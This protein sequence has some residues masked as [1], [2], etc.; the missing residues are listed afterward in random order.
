MRLTNFAKNIPNFI[1]VKM[2]VAVK[3]W[4][5]LGVFLDEPETWHYAL[6]TLTGKLIATGTKDEI[7]ELVVERRFHITR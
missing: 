5:S 7:D 4:P 2:D 1:S 6:R 3:H